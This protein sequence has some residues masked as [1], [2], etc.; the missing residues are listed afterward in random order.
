MAFTRGGLCER[1]PTQGAH[2][3]ETKRVWPER[4]LTILELGVG[5]EDPNVCSNGHFIYVLQ[6][7][8]ELVL[9]DGIERVTEG[10]AC[11]LDAGTAHR[12]RNAGSDPLRLLVLAVPASSTCGHATLP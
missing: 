6:G 8:L 7:T 5:F 9:D 3:L 2:P 1:T 4:G 10:D 11:T 12:A